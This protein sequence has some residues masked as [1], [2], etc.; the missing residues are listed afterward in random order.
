L[1][2]KVVPFTKD[3]NL[4]WVTFGRVSRITYNVGPPT[5]CTITLEEQILDSAWGYPPSP[6]FSPSRRRFEIEFHDLGDVPDF[7]I[8]YSVFQG[9]IN[10]QF[11]AGEQ[12]WAS[13]DGA[14]YSG[15]ITTQVVD[16]P[17]L[18][19]SLWMAFE[20]S[21]YVHFDFYLLRLVAFKLLT[22]KPC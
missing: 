9:G 16:D 6:Q 14:S 10:A 18:P 4:P 13:F 21:W 12:I 2:L 1:D 22:E 19:E 7:I 17:S 20:V 8:L 15:T 3:P 11:S 5:W